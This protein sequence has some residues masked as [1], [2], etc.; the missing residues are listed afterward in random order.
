MD[1]L[2]PCSQYD[3]MDPL[4]SWVGNHAY[5]GGYGGRSYVV[6]LLLVCVMMAGNL[7]LSEETTIK[8][9]EV[10]RYIQY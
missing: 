4:A 6:V 8:S 5:E 7:I 3:H 1:P 10:D 2:D 9:K